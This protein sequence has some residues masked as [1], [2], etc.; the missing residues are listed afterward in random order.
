M[1]G[2]I[3]WRWWWLLIPIFNFDSRQT[4]I[5]PASSHKSATKCNLFFNMQALFVSSCWIT[6]GSHRGRSIGIS[7]PSWHLPQVRC[8]G[9][10]R[11]R[12]L[13]TPSLHRPTTNS[14]STQTQQPILQPTL[15]V[16]NRT[17][18]YNTWNSL[19]YKYWPNST[20]LD[21]SGLTRTEAR[22]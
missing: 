21:F 9:M 14:V 3:S 19:P 18:T 15:R 13:C 20:L 1:K 12:G 4:K 10:F 5:R 16:C 7:N 17:H 22:F 6:L 11:P 2:I 8:Q